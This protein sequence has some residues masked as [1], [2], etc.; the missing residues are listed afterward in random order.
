VPALV[1]L[2]RFVGSG[3]ITEVLAAFG[4]FA[5]SF[6]AGEYALCLGGYVLGLALVERQA[7][8]ARRTGAIAAFALPGAVYD[9]NG[10]EGSAY[11]AYVNDHESCR[12]R[13]NSCWRWQ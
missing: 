10:G 5:L 12:D 13:R 4:L 8:I 9:T 2:A 6:L 7:P 3:R 11:S 1:L